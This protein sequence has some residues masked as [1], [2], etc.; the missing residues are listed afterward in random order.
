MTKYEVLALLI[1]ESCH[2][3]SRCNFKLTTG[4]LIVEHHEIY[5]S[6]LVQLGDDFIECPKIYDDEYKRLYMNHA[7]D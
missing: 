1:K 3:I 4:W 6:P 2:L 5:H 7:D